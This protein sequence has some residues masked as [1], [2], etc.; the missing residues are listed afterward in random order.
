MEQEE[1]AEEDFVHVGEGEKEGCLRV[2]VDRCDASLR[3]K[4]YCFKR[5][6]TI[7]SAKLHTSELHATNGS[8]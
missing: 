2:H 6:E 8:A 5:T 1:V 4:R 7:E 3:M